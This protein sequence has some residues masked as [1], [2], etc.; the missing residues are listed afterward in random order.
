MLDECSRF[1]NNNND[2]GL[3]KGS[4]EIKFVAYHLH[5]KNMCWNLCVVHQMLNR[6]YLWALERK[7]QETVQNVH[8][9]LKIYH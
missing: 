1:N 2:N 6:C 7:A 5:I 4:I 8:F 9:S 3:K